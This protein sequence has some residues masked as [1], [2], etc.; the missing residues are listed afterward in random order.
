MTPTLP[1]RILVVDDDKD[2]CQLCSDILIN[3]GYRVDMAENGEAGWQKLHGTRH[4]PDSYQL[5]ITDNNMP[6]LSGIELIKKLRLAHMALPVILA[7]GTAPLD[8]EWLRLA[9]ILHK[10]FSVDQLVDTVREVLHTV[11]Q[12]RSPDEHFIGLS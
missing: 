5:L 6:R 9:T 1:Q 10:P 12:A 4:D 2:I 3:S 7:S 8:N 11:N